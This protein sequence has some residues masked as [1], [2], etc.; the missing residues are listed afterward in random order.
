MELLKNGSENVNLSIEK[1]LAIN[2]PWP[3]YL[4]FNKN[5]FILAKRIEKGLQEM[6][7]DGSFEAIFLKYNAASIKQSN[8]KNRRIIKL[9]NPLLPKETPLHIESLW[10]D[11][12]KYH[13]EI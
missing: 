13:E 9:K 1:N 4:F 6:L 11:P 7:I 3:Y 5:D 2:Y 10:F 8:L 12:E